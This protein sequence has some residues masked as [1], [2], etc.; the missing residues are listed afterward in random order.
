MFGLLG[1]M[2]SKALLRG[3]L[4]CVVCSGLCGAS[5]SVI[6]ALDGERRRLEVIG[7]V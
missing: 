2:N 1:N 4:G 3:V 7:K 6:Y 5:R